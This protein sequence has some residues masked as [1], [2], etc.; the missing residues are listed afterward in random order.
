MIAPKETAL[1]VRGT[2]EGEKVAMGIAADAMGHIMNIMT[3]LYSDRELACIREYATNAHDAHIEAGVT[4]PIEVTTP[5]PLTPFL[6]IRD[7]G[8]GLTQDDIREIYSQYGKSTKRGTNDQVGMLGLG[9][10]SA[11][12]YT[13]QFSVVSVKDGQRIMVNVSRD[14]DGAGSMTLV[15]ESNTSDPNGTEI[16]IPARRDNGFDG[17]AREFFSYWQPGTV[18]VNGEPPEALDGLHITDNLVVSNHGSASRLV[19]GNVPYPAS[20]NVELNYNYGLTAFVPIGAVNFAPSREALMD[21]AATKATIAKVED[22]FRK[23][24]KGAIQR[25]VDEAPTPAEALRTI[26]R[27]QGMFSSYSGMARTLAQG[28]TYKGG[29]VPTEAPLPDGSLELP[30]SARVLSKHSKLRAVPSAMWDSAVWITNYDRPTFTAGQKKKINQW[31]LD[32]GQSPRLYVLV[33]G[34]VPAEAKD[35]IES[36]QIVDWSVIQ[37]IKLERAKP[38]AHSGRIAGSYDMYIDGSVKYGVEA[39]DIDTQHPVYYATGA[40]YDHAHYVS[41]LMQRGKT[42]FTVVCMGANR[43]AKFQRMFPKA[44]KLYDAVWKVHS[45]WLTTVSDEDLTALLMDTYE[46]R[47]LCLIDPKQ[48]DD[49]VL[50]SGARLAR[51]NVDK[52]T[53][54]HSDFRRVLGWEV[55]SKLRESGASKVIP[56]GLDSYPLMC[57]DTLRSNPD[58]VYRYINT[59]Y[60]AESKED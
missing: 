36:D 6:R 4:R 17:K 7:F 25:A 2:I 29:P 48:V 15:D 52:L 27:Y 14:E 12:T 53:K 34:P 3:D 43:L 13:N 60:A 55:E 20:F 47:T 40:T 30:G 46:R 21:T 44:T 39:S 33:R 10:K 41:F 45:D 38:Q 16:V 57:D 1:D 32:N 19:M 5:S 49:P 18:L 28:Y 8:V 56:T 50:A 54:A 58:H 35:W 42:K 26:L 37:A 23:H 31:A 22:D 51:R 9:C 11:L 59:A 24:V